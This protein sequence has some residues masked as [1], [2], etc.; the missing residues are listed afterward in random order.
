MPEPEYGYKGPGV[1]G[2]RPPRKTPNA[3]SATKSAASAGW[4]HLVQPAAVVVA[5][6]EAQLTMALTVGK[7]VRVYVW[8][9][10]EKRQAA[11]RAEK[12]WWYG[13]SIEKAVYWRKTFRK[14]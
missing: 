10:P 13:I 4:W 3:S 1:I 6:I 8:H 9:V 5:S 7:F 2:P 11:Q 14:A 12:T